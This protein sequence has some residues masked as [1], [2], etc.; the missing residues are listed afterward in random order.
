MASKTATWRLV[1]R[2]SGGIAATLVLSL[3]ACGRDERIAAPNR[4]TASPPQRP[5]LIFLLADDMRWD[6]AGYTGN[7]IVQT[8]N[9]D[10]LA[11]TGV[12]FRNAYVSSP[13]CAISRASIFTGQ[14]SRRHGVLDFS[15]QLS[16]EALAQTYPALLAAAGYRTGF[17]GKFG[18]GA[19]PPEQ[20]FD[21]WRGFAGNGDYET[22][23]SAG[24]PIHLTRLM[25]QQAIEFLE[26][27]TRDNPFVLSVSYKAP[28]VQDEDPRQF[29]PESVDRALYATDVIAPPVT[30]DYWSGFPAFFRTN[31]LGRERWELLFSTPDRYQASVKGYYRLISGMDRSIGVIRAALRRLNLDSNT[32]IIFSSDNGFFLGELGLS[33]KWYGMEPSVRVPL[34]MYDPRD[35]TGQRGRT[36]SAIALNVDIAPTLLDF[37]GVQIPER[38][39]GQSLTAA[40]RGFAIPSRGD[41]LFEHLLPEASIKRSTGVVGGRY[42]YLRYLDPTP[43]FEV[44]YDLAVDPNETIN[45]A[46]DGAYEAILD[47]LRQRHADL[48]ARAR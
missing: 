10:E 7:T 15:T 39:Q 9:L 2:L 30:A 29:I 47:S 11:H 45:F 24:R 31:N 6:A 23:D 3:G 18:V 26:R 34:I 19:N 35:L 25:T 16:P 1:A 20:L 42:K 17:I 27:Q 22:T 13:I 46:Q 43:N 38:M 28:H 5:N 41:F 37:A 4:P 36:E 21:Y 32:V 8:P 48:A 44:L 12:S 14:Y 40:T 33:H